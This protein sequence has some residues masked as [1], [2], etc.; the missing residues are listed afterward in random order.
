M[1]WQGL[2]Q[3]VLREEML[4]MASCF[5]IRLQPL[6]KLL[7]ASVNVNLVLEPMPN[8]RSVLPF[9]HKLRIL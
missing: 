7:I 3:L 9:G 1:P 2:K 5:D 8:A 6:N 4:V